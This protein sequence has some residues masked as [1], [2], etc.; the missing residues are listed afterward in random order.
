MKVTFYALADYWL[1]DFGE[2]VEF[3][4]TRGE[5]EA[6]LADVLH[7]EPLWEDELGVVPV[8]FPVTF[9]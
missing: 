8:E 4:V 7:D 3:Y 2:V 1:N 5:A 9:Q 6:A